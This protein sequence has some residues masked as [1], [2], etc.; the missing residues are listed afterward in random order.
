MKKIKL[1]LNL[2]KDVISNLQAKSIFGGIVKEDTDP[3][4]DNGCEDNEDK[5]MTCPLWS[6]GC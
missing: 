4:S 5:T 1:K 3:F 2:K 6:C